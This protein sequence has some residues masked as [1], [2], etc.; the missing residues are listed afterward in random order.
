MV[1]KRKLYAAFIWLTHC[2]QKT[3][4]KQRTDLEHFPQPTLPN[5]GTQT[6]KE[7]QWGGQNN[8]K[9]DMACQATSLL[10]QVTQ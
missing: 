5:P 1:Q 10:P 6:I 8:L 7:E 2:L 4:C 3:N 9:P